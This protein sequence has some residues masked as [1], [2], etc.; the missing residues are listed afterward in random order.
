MTELNR[1]T[2]Y[3]TISDYYDTDALDF[4][5]RYWSNKV[6][7]KIRQSF[8]E[9]V[10]QYNFSNV[11][12]IGYGTGI[13][14]IHFAKTHPDSNFYGID[15]SSEMFHKTKEKIKNLNV[16]NIDIACG[17]VE[18]IEDVFKGQKY[19]MI[20]V[21]FGALNTVADLKKTEQI[22][23]RILS[24][25][26]ILVLSFVNKY[27]LFGIVFNLFRLKWK[28][29]FSRLQKV[30]GGYS[31][32][33]SIPSRCYTPNQINQTYGSFKLI[34]QKGYCIVHPAWF[35][36]KLNTKLGRL[37]KYLWKIDMKLNKSCFRRFGEYSLYIFRAS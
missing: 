28:T 14:L 36:Q 11:L 32:S 7:Q 29:A 4:D 6:L 21:F 18:D 34:S 37:K 13:D 19:D 24:D 30:W 15:I 9:Q 26:G 35:Y 10:K 17:S 20:Y 25:Q 23:K 8:R 1:T 12:E 5:K 22:F 2:F 31:P 3:K 33:K 27:Y 16:S